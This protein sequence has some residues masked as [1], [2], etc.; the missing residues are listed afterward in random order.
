MSNCAIDLY[1]QEVGRQLDLPKQQRSKL[2]SGLRQDLENGH[3]AQ[4]PTL[5]D[6]YA[7]LGAP[8][9]TAETLMESVPAAVKA[10]YRERRKRKVKWIVASLAVLLVFAVGLYIYLA[11]T[12]VTRAEFYIIDKGTIYEEQGDAISD[13]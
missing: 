3:S 2:L 9:E 10:R 5:P 4:A 1:C 8:E 7:E 6:L 13:P 12:Q 11:K